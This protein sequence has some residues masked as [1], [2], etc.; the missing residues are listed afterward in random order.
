MRLLVE[1]CKYEKDLIKDILGKV[2]AHDA[3]DG[4]NKFRYVGYL[5]SDVLNEAVFFLPKVIVYKPDETSD[6]DKDKKGK[7][8]GE[9]DPISLAGKDLNAIILHEKETGD[10]TRTVKP[11]QK[12]FLLEF[13]IRIYRALVVFKK[14][15]TDK[16]VSLEEPSQHSGSADVL[17]LR[18]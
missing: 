1:G 6:S 8:F 7:V 16:S 15:N 12:E 3:L 13:A 4:N 18:C 10:A 14:T 11:K 2:I 9:I 5:W 17:H